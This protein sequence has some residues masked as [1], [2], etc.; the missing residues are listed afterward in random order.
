MAENKHFKGVSG[1]QTQKKFSIPGHPGS[2][3]EENYLTFGGGVN[4][5]QYQVSSPQDSFLKPQSTA[6]ASTIRKTGLTVNCLGDCDEQKASQ[7]TRET[8]FDER[9]WHKWPLST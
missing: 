8:A 5:G 3:L 1:P 7:A 2:L 6:K 9:V 4:V